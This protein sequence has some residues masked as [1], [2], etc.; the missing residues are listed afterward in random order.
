MKTIIENGRY[1]QIV[2]TI[3]NIN[4]IDDVTLSYGTSWKES[5]SR[6]FKK[7]GKSYNKR[8]HCNCCGKKWDDLDKIYLAFT[9][10]GN[11]LI[12]GECKIKLVG[13]ET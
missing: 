12:C 10:K 2:T 11:K 7:D 13:G 3:I 9:D 8:M 6:L 4:N 5:V 1:K